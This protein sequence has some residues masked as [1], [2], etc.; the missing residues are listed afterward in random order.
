MTLAPPSSPQSS[1]PGVQPLQLPWDLRLNADQFERVCQANPDACLVPTWRLFSVH[2]R[3]VQAVQ[4]Q[5]PL[6]QG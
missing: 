6:N 3:S 2:R 5:N 1:P 4:N